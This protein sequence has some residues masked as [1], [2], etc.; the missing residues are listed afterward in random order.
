[1]KRTGNT[2][3]HNFVMSNDGSRVWPCLNLNYGPDV[4]RQNGDKRFCTSAAFPDFWWMYVLSISAIG[5]HNDTD[6]RA[7]TVIISGPILRT[8]MG[9]FITNISEKWICV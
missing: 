7:N 3:G 6:E 5:L 8:D 2:S 4:E 1:M 9:I